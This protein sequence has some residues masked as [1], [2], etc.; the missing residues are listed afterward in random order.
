MRRLA[1]PGDISSVLIISGA[2]L[3]IDAGATL[4]WQE[5]VTAADRRDRAQQVNKQYLSYTHRSAVAAGPSTALI[6]LP[7]AGADRVPG[8]QGA[9]PGRHRRRDRQIEIPTI[10]ADLHHHPG[11]RHGEPRGRP[12]PLSRRRRSRAWAR[13]S[14]SPATGPRIWRR[15]GTST[16]LIHGRPDRRARCHTG[17]SPMWSSTSRSCSRP[18]SGVIDNVGYERLVLSACNPLYSAAQRIIVFARLRTCNPWARPARHPASPR[19]AAPRSS[20]C[21]ALNST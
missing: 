8:A 3:L 14:R 18:T 19:W 6:G 1:H 21:A 20:G 2:L 10:G 16:T 7:S 9:A 15:S 12:R 13:R 17:G 5:P 4:L 11:H